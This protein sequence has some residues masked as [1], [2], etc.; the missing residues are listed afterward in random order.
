MSDAL[1]GIRVKYI[2]RTNGLLFNLGRL[3]AVAKVKEIVIKDFLFVDE[4]TLRGSS[5]QKM[6]HGM[7]CNN[8]GLAIRTKKTE[9]MNQPAPGKLPYFCTNQCK[10]SLS[11]NRTSRLRSISYRLLKASPTRAP[12]F[13]EQLT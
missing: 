3:Q 5:E 2:Y 7:D 11:R 4:C 10:K 8:F 12:I 1:H 9:V 13:Q 6:Q